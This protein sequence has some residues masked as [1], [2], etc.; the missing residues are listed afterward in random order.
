[1]QIESFKKERLFGTDGIRGTPGKYPLTDG[2]IFKIGCSIARIISYKKAGNKTHKIV[3]GKDTRLTAR[4][5]ETV[6]ADA[7]NSY[8]MDVLLAGIIPTPGLSFLT[9]KLN[10]D[11][12]IMI[13]AS[14]NKP[15]DNG[16]KFFN[17]HGFKLSYDEE[18]WIENIIFSSLI[19]TPNDIGYRRLGKIY[20]L[21]GARSKYVRFL[22]STVKGLNLKGTSII[23][24]CAWGAASG[25]AKKLFKTLGASVSAINDTPSGQN[26]NGS[27][28]VNPSALRQLVM[29]SKPSMGIALDGDADRAILVDEKGNLLD[30]DSILAILA[31]YLLKK[32]KLSKNSL[33]ATVMSNLGLKI[34]LENQGARIIL[35]KVGDKHVLR[36]LLKKGLNL[37][38]EQS[39][40]IIFL[41]YLPTP[42]GLLTA[43][44]V[45]KVIKD[46]GI[47]LSKL[48]QC[49][50]KVPQVLVNV[51]V[52]EKRPFEE[53]SSVR[54]R[55]RD[56]NSQLN[57]EGRILLR[58]SG[59]E[60]LARIMVEGKD[61]NL[62][63]SIAHSLAD[64][65]KKEIG[66]K[67]KESYA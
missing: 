13:S 27:G 22:I 25:F 26:I 33:V 63:T 4:R 20:P 61:K 16:I 49:I 14:H 3:I 44:Q 6:L 28:A 59:T 60:S 46:T 37:G 21:K 47:P 2:M 43:L 52:K 48:S 58:Y 66:F 55:L 19:H 54:N 65:I 1:M 50:T 38:G 18:E 12:G 31:T 8:G 62:I 24:D 23:L 42:D 7:I 35:T 9:R 15:T 11:M 36:E 5:I 67:P 29:V 41:D 45:L 30:G 56:F 40:H 10:A 17:S 39:G 34:Y 57:D 64:L 32:N 53:M 51:K